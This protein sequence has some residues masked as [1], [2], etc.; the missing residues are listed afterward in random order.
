MENQ[1]KTIIEKS[2]KKAVNKVQWV[3]T[4]GMDG[5]VHRRQVGK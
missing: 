4:V 1:F 5:N 3:I 2:L